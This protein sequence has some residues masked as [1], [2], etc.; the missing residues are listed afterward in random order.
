MSRLAGVAHADA[1]VD[2]KRKLAAVMLPRTALGLAALS[3]VVGLA[4]AQGG[5]F[6]S[7]WNWAALG[8]LW[9]S[10]MAFLLRRA[11]GLTRLELTTLLAFAALTAWTLLSAAWSIE[12][13]Q[14]VTEAQRTLVYLAALLALFL[15]AGRGSVGPLLAGVCGGIAIICAY[16]LA[17]RLFPERFGVFDPSTGYRLSAPIG[18][19]NGLG[20]FAA[21]AV[22]L[23]ACLVADLRSLPWRS[24]AAPAVVLCLPTV[25]FT[26]S[27]GAWLALA[28]GLAAAVALEPR[29]LRLVTT[30]LALAP[31]AA[32]AV[33]LSSRPT[34]LRKED[35]GLAA[36]SHAGHRLALYLALLSLAAGAVPVI[37]AAVGRR[38]RP[39]IQ[40]RRAY[41]VCL[42]V[43]AAGALIGA[44]V[45]EGGPGKVAARV[46]HAF[47]SPPPVGSNLNSRLTSFSGS[48]R[49]KMWRVAWDDVRAHP[50]LGSGAGS[51]ERY[52]DRH[53][54][55]SYAVRD[56]HSLYLEVLAELG[57][58]GLG[59]LVL[60]LG[61]PIA[62]SLRARRNAFVPAAFGAYVAYLVH[63]AGDWD[64]ELAGVTV[65]ALL[66]GGTL[67][68]ATRS[69]SGGELKSASRRFVLGFALLP[70]IGSVIVALFGN[71]ASEAAGHALT[72]SHTA[73]ALREARRAIRWTPW[74]GEPWNLLGQA[75]LAQG[76]RSAAKA[77]FRRGIAKDG[78]NWELW[79][80]LAL[81]SSGRA[82]RSA[83]DR[84][85]R[86][87]P[88]EPTLVLAR[89]LGFRY[90]DPLA[91]VRPGRLR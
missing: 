19:W 12:P 43:A 33:W 20:I 31:P 27:R 34:A 3:L 71:S 42:I 30:L 85:L 49:Q 50:V 70:V 44:V 23:A 26:F 90:V 88:K 29:R 51:Y 16:S 58:L 57:P 46:H 14:G 47:D 36:A 45:Y 21:L 38:W 77:S 81:A 84:A 75:Q 40:L 56:A 6:P 65:T 76:N 17:T 61:T 60:A 55:I 66:I 91:V 59:L 89:S 68:L 64:W 69:E 39:G 82:R 22:V 1:V 62:A 18:Y 78:G 24:L 37:A 87:N 86:L 41:A 83:L 4:G 72:S 80:G 28:I 54:D 53:R 73:S 8:L 11:I 79:Y 63:A 7:T 9:V 52:W 74:S 32:V 10:V 67:L 15:V 35:A 25:Y 2:D 5:Y 13:S 48:W